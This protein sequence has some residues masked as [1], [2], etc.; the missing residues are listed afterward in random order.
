MAAL[1]PRRQHCKIVTLIFSRILQAACGISRVATV[2]EW[3]LLCRNEHQVHKSF[4]RM[5]HMMLPLPLMWAIR[6]Y[7]PKYPATLK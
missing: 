7:Q 3:R 4:I 5:V 6:I 2:W 1:V